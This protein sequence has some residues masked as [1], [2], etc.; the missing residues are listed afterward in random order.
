MRKLFSKFA[1]EESGAT[2]VEYGVALVVAIVVGGAALSS[3]ATETSATMDVS[4]D[5]LR[6]TG[7]ALSSW[8]DTASQCN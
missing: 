5:A 6:P 7:E 8:D 1:K 4:C 3:L 2:L